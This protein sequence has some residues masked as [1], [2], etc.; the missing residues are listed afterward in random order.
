M[1]KIN[2]KVM[3]IRIA[4]S[5]IGVFFVGASVGVFQSTALGNDP[6]SC[7]N[8]S[9]SKVIGWDFSVWQLL[10]NVIIFIPSLLFY[11]KAIGFG[12]IFN[13]VF[14]GVFADIIRPLMEKYAAPH[15]N[16]PIRLFLMIFAVVLICVGVALYVSSDLGMAPYDA[17]AYILQKFTGINFSYFRIATDI[18]CVLLGFFFGLSI[19]IQF[20][21]VGI[22]TVITAFG[23]GPIVRLFQEKIFVPLMKKL[24]YEP[25]EQVK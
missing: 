24:G 5:I 11:R 2:Y 16:F 22:G 21:V 8:T 14:V 1:K 3:A 20:E 19:G 10:L 13:M 12:T 18:I 4:A 6:F 17:L 15:Y 7:M 9:I 25:K 23:T